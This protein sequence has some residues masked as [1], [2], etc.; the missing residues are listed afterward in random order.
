MSGD[1]IHQDITIQSGAYIAGHCRPE[2]GKPEHKQTP[3]A[4]NKE[5]AQ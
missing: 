3:A 1:V 2:Y 5:A 4:R